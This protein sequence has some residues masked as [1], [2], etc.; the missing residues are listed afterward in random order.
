MDEQVRGS[1]EPAVRIQAKCLAHRS[2]SA[3]REFVVNLPKAET[4][5]PHSRLLSGS[6]VLLSG[7]GVVI[8]FNFAYNVAVAR[9]LGPT[10][11]GHASAVY[12][13]LI[14]MSAVTLSFQIVA[15]KLVAQQESLAEGGAGYKR[16]HRNA[17]CCGI[18]VG[19]LLFL[20]RGAISSYLNLPDPLL[21]V[22]L[23]IGI[24]FYVPLGS[25]RG[26]VQGAC[27]FG[28][29]AFN[30][31]LE[32]AVRLGGSLLLVARGYGVD[33]VIAANTAAVAVA[34]AFAHPWSRTTKSAES[35]VRVAFGEGLQAIIFFAGMVVINNC[36]IIVVKHFF[37]P[38]W[39]GVYAAVALVGRV[40]FASS[41]AVIST[42]FP[43]VA[44]A[45]SRQRTHT[46][47]LP[48]SLL[49][50]F[51]ICATV[52]FGLRFAPEAIWTG[53]FGSQFITA[54]EYSFSYLLCLYAATATLYSFSVVLICYEMS[55]RIANTGWIQLA[56]AAIMIGGIYRFHA[57]LEQVIW[58][59]IIMMALLLL[60]VALPFLLKFRNR[61]EQQRILQIQGIRRVRR[62]TEDEVIAEFLS[63]DFQNS[64]FQ[65]YHQ[66]LRDEVLFPDLSNG[67]ENAKR[68]ALF[69]M[70]HGSLWR[71]LP[72]GTEWH[73]V[74]IQPHDLQRIR[75]F[76]RAQWRKLARGNFAATEVARSIAR[77]NGRRTAAEK[78]IAKIDHLRQ[79]MR[80]GHVS[81]A[82]LLIGVDE[83]GPLT[84][85]DGNH[86][87]IA[88][89][90]NLP[91]VHM[92]L[93]FFCG[94][95]PRMTQCCWYNTN[96]ATLF[97]YGKNLVRHAI[98][99]PEADLTQLLQNS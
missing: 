21:I 33:G 38:Q 20:F 49:L 88:A 85:L 74:A 93:R 72:E 55:Y 96:L 7:Y 9:F 64:E 2:L 80:N 59:Q 83:N 19:L 99:D 47:V 92:T 24:V 13:L 90:L 51:V 94:L 27:R 35:P 60:V 91:E 65:N 45:R 34:Y 75:V 31:V 57:S 5:S 54:S 46:G 89:T 22:L 42:M 58:V 28:Y 69:F 16:L 1:V 36:D 97:H 32:G 30:L 67:L 71:E 4:P 15:A 17:W 14:L 10:S 62:V 43:V 77:G 6:F 98:Q 40:I 3:F 73:E 79:Q 23:A 56:F 78:F 12:T 52:T 63:N 50:V 81:G 70:R 76:P 25:R 53:L 82:V 61:S 44:G 37:R 66:V 26:Y 48:L 68:R 8:A 84:V 87:L 39:A 95:S 18:L 86:R 29:L 11:F 41:W